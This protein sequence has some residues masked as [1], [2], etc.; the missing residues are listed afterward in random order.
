MTFMTEIQDVF[1]VIG[2]AAVSIFQSGIE[3]NQDTM[4]EYLTDK[5]TF[6]RISKNKRLEAAVSVAFEQLRQNKGHL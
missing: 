5:L 2:Q 4:E 3:I 6:A 1:D